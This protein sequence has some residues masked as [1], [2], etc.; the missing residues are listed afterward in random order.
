MADAQLRPHPDVVWRQVGDE[1]VLVNLKTNRIYAL[2]VTGARLWELLESGAD[3]PAIE[4]TMLS[5]FDVEA[6]Q[7]QE[8]ID[9]QLDELSR[10]GLLA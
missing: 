5:E 4:Q 1:V 3:R 6:T 8:E 2:N 7:L 9:R 10:E